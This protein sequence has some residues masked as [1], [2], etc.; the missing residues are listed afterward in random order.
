M[1]KNTKTPLNVIHD[2][3]VAHRFGA[4]NHSQREDFSDLSDEDLYFLDDYLINT[5][6]EVKGD[7]I[8]EQNQFLVLEQRHN[9]TSTPLSSKINNQEELFVFVGD[10][11]K[12]SK[13]P[14]KPCGDSCFVSKLGMG[15]ADGVG[16]WGSYGI[17]PSKF[18]QGLMNNCKIFIDEKYER[19]IS[20]IRSN[21]NVHNNKVIFESMRIQKS[22]EIKLDYDSLVQNEDSED[23]E[24][25]EHTCSSREHH[26]NDFIAKAF[27]QPLRKKALKRTR[28][29]FHLD[30]YNLRECEKDKNDVSHKSNSNSRRKSITALNIKIEP[31]TVIKESF[32]LV[33]D[34]GSSTV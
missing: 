26:Q 5:P 28:S 17:D 23:S 10:K 14:S 27:G 15:I 19:I 7:S 8:L 6:F 34:Y 12:I 3:I 1:T 29:S 20:E 30:A 24:S 31:R 33:E 2:P 21:N 18:S 16:G 32:K 22:D 11:V 25:D 13:N 9:T 4:E